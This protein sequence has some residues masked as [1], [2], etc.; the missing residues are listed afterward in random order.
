M[1]LS[2]DKLISL[3]KHVSKT[4]D[5]LDKLNQGIIPEKHKNH[6]K[7]FKIFLEHE[8][9]TTMATLNAD[10]DAAMASGS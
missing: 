1:G 5:S 10:K 3:N 8:I 4:K 9:A 7:S 2:K 6:A